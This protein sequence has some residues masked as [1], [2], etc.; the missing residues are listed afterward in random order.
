[1]NYIIEAICVGL[2]TTVIY[3]FFH[4]F[5]KNVY[6]LLLV[7]GFFKHFISNIFRIH[8]Y[9]CNYGEACIK[10]NER[11]KSYNS[12]SQ[13]IVYDS[14]MESILFLFLGSCLSIELTNVYLFFTIG[15]VLHILFEKLGIHKWFC[16]KR[17]EKI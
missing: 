6:I 11:N 2:Y 15:F 9:Y 4:Y 14:I 16:E 12:D 8:T 5:I 1:M 3:L 7:V 13:Y 10:V 17:C